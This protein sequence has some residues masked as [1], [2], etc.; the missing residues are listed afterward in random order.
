MLEELEN[1]DIN[2]VIAKIPRNSSVSRSEQ[3]TLY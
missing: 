1:I 2:V 3:I